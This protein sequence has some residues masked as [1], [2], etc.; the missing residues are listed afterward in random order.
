MSTLMKIAALIVIS[1]L[2]IS[3]CSSHHA[4]TV[5]SSTKHDSITVKPHKDSMVQE[6]EFVFSAIDSLNKYHDSLNYVISRVKGRFGQYEYH[7]CVGFANGAAFGIAP[8]NDSTYSFFVNT[9]NE[10][11]KKYDLP[12]DFVL[13]DVEFSDLL[14]NGDSSLVLW[15]A[16][17]FGMSGNWMNLIFTFNRKDKAFHYCHGAEIYNSRF[18]DKHKPIIS[19]QWSCTNGTEGCKELYEI[20]NDSLVFLKGVAVGLGLSTADHRPYIRYYTKKGDEQ[21]T[22][23]QI[24]YKNED[25]LWPVYNHLFWDST[26]SPD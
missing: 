24:S 19:S 26:D 9:N 20:K 14:H 25:S 23:K 3:S 18:R 5:D 15:S 4:K 12:T 10:W 1:A 16:N 13:G 11:E 8:I 22:L 2:L 7:F 6:H 17:S 21:I